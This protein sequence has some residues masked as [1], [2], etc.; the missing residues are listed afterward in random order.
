MAAGFLLSACP[1]SSLSADFFA[2][3]ASA[4][5]PNCPYHAIDVTPSGLTSSGEVRFEVR[6]AGGSTLCPAPDEVEWFGV[7]S[8]LERFNRVPDVSSAKVFLVKS[9]NPSEP[10]VIKTGGIQSVRLAAKATTG[11]SVSY[12]QADFMAFGQSDAGPS[13]PAVSS[14]NSFP[15]PDWPSL[16][17]ASSGELYWPQTGHSFT[18]DVSAP[19]FSQ[20][21]MAVWEEGR[22]APTALVEADFFGKFVYVPPRDPDLD[23]AGATAAKRLAFVAEFP[24]G[25]SASL[26]LKIHRSRVAS[27]SPSLGLGLFGATLVVGG[28]LLASS[29][30][31]S[32]ACA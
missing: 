20:T 27:M 26:T 19:L 30:R 15:L 16:S 18:I 2:P 29:R 28:A 31:R 7:F 21:P 1:T 17:L 6:V 13:A 10:L 14:L 32:L 23:A 5:V 22:E 3:V 4:S 24:G 25:I 8:P 12:A 9:S 11:K